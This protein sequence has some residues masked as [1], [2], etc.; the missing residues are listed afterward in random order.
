MIV[1]V[2][3]TRSRGEWNVAVKVYYSNINSRGVF[4]IVL[5]VCIFNHLSFNASLM[6]MIGAAICGIILGTLSAFLNHKRFIAPI[7]VIVEHIHQLTNGKLGARTELSEAG[8]LKGIAKSLNEMT[9]TWESIIN[10]VNETSYQ[11]AFL[12]EELSAKAG[13]TTA[14]TKQVTTTI[15]EVAIGSEKQVQSVEKSSQIVAEMSASA[16]QIASNAQ[17][18]SS[19]ANETLKVA[20]QGNEKIQNAVAQMNSIHETVNGLSDVIQELGERSEQ[21]GQIVKVITGIADQTN[22]LALN[23]AIEAARA[24]E[25]GKGF[26]VVADEVRK[27][28]EQSALSSKQITNL[29]QTIQV[30]TS[31]AVTS[32]ERAT[33]EVFE[34]IDVVHFAGE[35]F[36]MIQE[37]VQTVTKQIQEVSAASEQMSTGVTHVAHSI[38]EITSVSET[39]AAGTQTVSAAAEQ[40]LASMEEITS[41]TFT[42]AKVAEELQQLTKKFNV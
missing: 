42:L 32:M 33:K 23:A 2:Y 41:S 18:V 9:E 13:Q 11:V 31:K 24:G 30:E 40:Q 28:A 21:I 36:Y 20:G 27:L 29:I 26:A 1:S 5:G 3:I 14:A 6:T 38:E 39:N 7:E 15:H 37:S 12:S 19:T 4:L 10:K 25:H 35:A 8:M 22:L 16:N 17:I 34:G